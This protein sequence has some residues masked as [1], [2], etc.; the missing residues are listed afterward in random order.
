MKSSCKILFYLRRDRVN[1]DGKAPLFCRITVS[2]EAVRF[3]LTLSCRPEIW[4]SE[5]ARATGRGQEAMEINQALENYH[6]SILKTYRQILE[7]DNYVT[8]EKVRDSFLGFSKDNVTLLSIFDDIIAET[9]SLIGISKTPA[10]LQKYKVTRSHICNFMATKYKIKDIN[11]KEIKYQFVSDFATYLRTVGKCG[12]NTTAKFLQFFKRAT[13]IA[14]RNGWIVGDPFGNYKISIA[15]VDRGYL[16]DDELKKIIKKEFATERLAQVRDIFIFAC[17]TG[18][19]YIDAKQL[20]YE[21]IVT[22]FN[23]KPWIKSKRE[24][25]N[26]NV[27]VPLM[28][29]PLAIIEK[30]RGKQPHNLVLPVLSNQK[31]NAYLKEIADLCGV[32]KNMSFHLARHTF[33]TTVTLGKGVPIE[34]VS[35]MLGHTNIQTT[36]IYARITNEKIGNDMDILSAKLKQGVI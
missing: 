21:N 19:A 34:S 15:K 22:G 13:L 4:N 35:K 25:T 5:F 36:Q 6:A 11:I 18:L 32:T 9:E 29:V 2:G 17:Y 14:I 27:N 28:K 24:K 26:T 1:K 16:T 31:M 33:A 20:T 10:T 12:A 23:G 30:Y 3:N 8:A 7:R